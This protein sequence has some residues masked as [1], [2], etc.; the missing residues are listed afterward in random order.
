[1]T[2]H[3]GLCHVTG[4]VMGDILEEERIR[5]CFKGVSQ[6]QKE[7]EGVTSGG[8]CMCKGVEDREGPVCLQYEEMFG[9]AGR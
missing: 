2:T 9:E 7:G 5:Q 3:Y 4:R 1:M 6:R 8:I